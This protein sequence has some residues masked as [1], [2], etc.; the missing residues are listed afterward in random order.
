ML[1][2]EI[3]REAKRAWCDEARVQTAWLKV[4]NENDMGCQRNG[5]IR[6]RWITISW[7]A[8]Q[9]SR[10]SRRRSLRPWSAKTER[11]RG[12]QF[13]VLSSFRLQLTSA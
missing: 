1:D 2:D 3:Q 9:S 8:R 11:E 6:E 5:T 13:G 10:T 12:G 4:L 7:V